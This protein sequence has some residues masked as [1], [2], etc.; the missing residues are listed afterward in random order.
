MK[1]VTLI[2]DLDNTLYNFVDG[3]A[4]SIRAMVHV[5]SRET[6]APEKMIYE[7]IAKVYR[8]FES[9]EYA[10]IVQKLEIVN[11]MDE[12]SLGKLVHKARVAFS[13]T[14]A[15]R[16]RLY[17]NVYESLY[18]LKLSG[19]T[20]VALTNAPE[21]HAFRRLRQLGISNLFDA[22][23][24]TKPLLA[25]EDMSTGG[26]NITIQPSI[27]L[28]VKNG[29]PS[30]YPF[31]CAKELFPNS[32]FYSLGD[33]V[34]NDL[35]PSRSINATTIF[36]SYGSLFDKKNFET[37]LSVTH[38]SSKKVKDTYEYVHFQP[39]FSIDRFEDVIDVI[40]APQLSLFSLR[41]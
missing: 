7:Q 35:I 5:L 2:C 38:W 25:K 13:R 10:F 9:I 1:E 17:P 8:Q 27:A 28:D 32:E 16:L 11:G 31:K 26:Y 18:E 39:D 23:I 19:V 41:Q 6:S 34:R 22:M 20:L 15:K 33:S 21:Y 29:K 36:A 30:T 40:A 3:I 12:V 37:L 14:R 24:S 4:P